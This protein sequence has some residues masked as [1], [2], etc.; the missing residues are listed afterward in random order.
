MYIG[1]PWFYIVM[2]FILKFSNH[3]DQPLNTG[4]YIT[5]HILFISLAIA[6]L[7][8]YPN[9]IHPFADITIGQWANII[10]SNR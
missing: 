8:V 7:N 3:I 4:I 6:V 1:S 10:T 9:N 2:Y 5:Y